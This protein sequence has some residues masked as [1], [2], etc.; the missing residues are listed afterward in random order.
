MS[1]STPMIPNKFVYV[2]SKRFD[3]NDG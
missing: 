2:W 1:D 3:K